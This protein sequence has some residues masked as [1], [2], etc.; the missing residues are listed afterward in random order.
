MTKEESKDAIRRLCH[1]WRADY[2][3]AN[4]PEGELSFSVFF[5]WLQQHHPGYL[6]FRTT[7]SVPGD[8]EMWFDQEFKQIW[9]R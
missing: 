6:R 8:V 7:T 9:R 1:T 5:A 4:T 3:Y 2:G